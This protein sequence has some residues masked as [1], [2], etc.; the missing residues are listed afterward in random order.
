MIAGT[1]IGNQADRQNIWLARSLPRRTVITS[2]ASHHAPR[3]G[4][5]PGTTVEDDLHRR[6]Q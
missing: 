4:T 3:R 2:D 1:A 5:H 6:L